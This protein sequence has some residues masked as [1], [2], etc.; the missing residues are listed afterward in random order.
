MQHR[1]E[2]GKASFLSRST[3]TLAADALPLIRGV[4]EPCRLVVGLQVGTDFSSSPLRNAGG[5]AGS[6]ADCPEAVNSK[7]NR[8]RS[9]S[10]IPIPSWAMG[11]LFGFTEN[12]H[13]S[14]RRS[15]STATR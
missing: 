13:L 7:P 12:M 9:R 5:T 8:A 14:P 15:C 1:V 11:K 10:V 3:A 6:F 4:A 2:C